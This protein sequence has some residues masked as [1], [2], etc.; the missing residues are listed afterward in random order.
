MSNFRPGILVYANC[1]GGVIAHALRSC[2]TVAAHYR[3][4]DWE[5]F[6]DDCHA[7]EISQ[8]FK[9]S[10]K[11]FLH[12]VGEWG[13]KSPA[14]KGLPD[15]VLTLHFPPVAS[16]AHFP[17]RS[18]WPKAVEQSPW[19]FRLHI[20]FSDRIAIDLAQR[21]PDKAAYLDA[22]FETDINDEIDVWRLHELDMM[23]M[24]RNEAISDI[25]LSD[26]LEDMMWR[27][28]IC[29]LPGHMANRFMLVLMQRLLT[30]LAD[31]DVP[32][33][34]EKRAD[35]ERE[36]K[37][38]F[39]GEELFDGLQVPVHPQV[40]ATMG[41]KWYRPDERCRHGDDVVWTHREYIA[42]LHDY[43]NGRPL[44][45]QVGRTSF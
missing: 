23:W 30:G 14:A 11:L 17:L 7:Q 35:I 40:A 24:N 25:V 28:R 36:L 38:V 21:I 22:Y 3:V 19:P 10:C 29:W 32:V 37:D 18:D 20:D 41:F 5:N 26:A 2:P 44:A 39:A 1:Q 6:P 45:A 34:A 42:A 9:D 43:I 31:R 16:N 12:Q 13:H 15:D 4:R 8:S 33:F 27:H